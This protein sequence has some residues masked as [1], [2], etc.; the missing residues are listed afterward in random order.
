VR[1]L[2]PILVLAIA[3]GG[4]PPRVNPLIDRDL[5]LTLQTEGGELRAMIDGR[6][7]LHA[8]KDRGATLSLQLKPGTH[9]MSLRGKPAQYGGMGFVARLVADGVAVIDLSCAL[10]CDDATLAAWAASVDVE[11]GGRSDPCADA[12]VRGVSWKSDPSAAGQDVEVRLTIDLKTPPSLSE[13][14][15]R[16]CR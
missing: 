8:Q 1:T 9:E 6:E 15:A 12:D 2:L 3:C 14:E 4:S 13:R 5:L 10:P 16:G 11:R 7:Q